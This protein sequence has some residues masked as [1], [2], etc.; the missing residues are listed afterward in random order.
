MLKNR[1]KEFRTERGLTL[2]QLA[3]ATGLSVGQISKIENNK[4][5][6]SPESLHRLA[7]ALNVPVGQLIDASGAWADAPL[8][9]V[10]GEG[11]EIRPPAN[12]KKRIGVKAP[13]AF[14]D[15]L[16]VTVVE[17]HLYPRHMRNERLFFPKDAI[18]CEDCVGRECWVWLESGISL[19]RVVHQGAKPGVYNLTS[20]N[21][22]PLYDQ[23]IVACRPLIYAS[24]AE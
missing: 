2:E 23:P 14:G 22:P 19:L 7:Q 5:G 16:A 17:D 9:G 6:W 10:I 13:A 12:N 18:P 24:P 21:Q 3:D 8:L 1:V 15:L 4:R 20:H 11:G